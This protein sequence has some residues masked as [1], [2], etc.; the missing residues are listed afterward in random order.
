[1]ENII[2]TDGHFQIF[3]GARKLLDKMF[4]LTKVFPEIVFHPLGQEQLLAG[5]GSRDDP[6]SGRS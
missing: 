4:L 6:G 3:G 1:M 2:Y 5:R